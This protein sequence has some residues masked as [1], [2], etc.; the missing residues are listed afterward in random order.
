MKDFEHT[1]ASSRM[2]VDETG[3]LNIMMSLN[4][5]FDLLLVVIE[6]NQ[7]SHDTVDQEC[8][9]SFCDIDENMPLL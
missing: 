1:L 4:V 7:F 2:L 3:L 8:I 6:P 5:N 9:A